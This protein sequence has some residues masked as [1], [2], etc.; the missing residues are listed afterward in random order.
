MPDLSPSVRKGIRVTSPILGSVAIV[1]IE[2]VVHEGV[3]PQ[4]F[5]NRFWLRCYIG[6]L[7]QLVPMLLEVQ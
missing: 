5:K 6:V 1:S 4:A 2:C 3:L 7:L